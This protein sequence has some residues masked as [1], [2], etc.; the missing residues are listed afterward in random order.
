MRHDHFSNL[1]SSLDVSVAL[2]DSSWGVGAGHWFNDNV[3]V[4]GAINDANGFGATG[5]HTL[6]SLGNSAATGE[7]ILQIA[8]GQLALWNGGSRVPID[9]ANTLGIELLDWS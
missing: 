8:D 9:T 4:L 2:P 7:V 5:I 6:L 1:V 3:Y